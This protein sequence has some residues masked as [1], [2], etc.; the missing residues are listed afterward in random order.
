MTETQSQS[1]SRFVF[2]DWRVTT[3]AFLVLA[4]GN[5]HNVARRFLVVRSGVTA[6]LP[7][8]LTF[9]V[10]Q[11]R[12]DVVLQLYRTATNFDYVDVGTHRCSAFLPPAVDPEV[13]VPT[14]ES[15]GCGTLHTCDLGAR[16]S[17]LGDHT[18]ELQAGPLQTSRQ[19]C[20][21]DSIYLAGIIAVEGYWAE[22]PAYFVAS[23]TSVSS[24]NG[25][26]VGTATLQLITSTGTSSTQRIKVADL[27]G[28]GVVLPR[29]GPKLGVATSL[30]LQTMSS[31]TADAVICE[32]DDVTAFDM[33]HG[34]GN[35]QR[36]ACVLAIDGGGTRECTTV[37]EYHSFCFD[38][39]DCA[40]FTTIVRNVGTTASP[41]VV[42]EPL[43]LHDVDHS[44]RATDAAEAAALGGTATLFYAKRA[45]ANRTCRF[46][47]GD[48]SGRVAVYL[49][50][51]FFTG[52]FAQVHVV[53]TA[54][55]RLT[56]QECG[57]TKQFA[58]GVFGTESACD[59]YVL[60]D[61]VTVQAE[62]TLEVSFSETLWQASCDKGV[63]AFATFS[64][65]EATDALIIPQLTAADG[66]SV[67]SLI[68]P[69]TSAAR[70]NVNVFVIGADVAFL[71]VLQTAFEC[72]SEEC[73]RG[74][75]IAIRAV[76]EQYVLSGAPTADLAVMGSC[77]GTETFANGVS[78]LSG[79]CALNFDC[80][81]SPL[82]LNAGSSFTGIVAISVDAAALRATTRPFTTRSICSEFNAAVY[83]RAVDAVEGVPVFPLSV[84]IDEMRPL[85]AVAAGQLNSDAASFVGD[86]SA[87]SLP[88]TADRTVARVLTYGP[89]SDLR[90][91]TIVRWN[92]DDAAVRNGLAANAAFGC[93]GDSVTGTTT[94]CRVPVP[95][96]ANFVR[97]R[98]AQTDFA[99]NA[100]TVGFE[101]TDS[102]AVQTRVC[103]AADSFLGLWPALGVRQV[104]R[105]CQHLSARDHGNYRQRRR[106]RAQ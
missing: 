85:L 21:G 53:D 2:T 73:R 1:E 59:Q 57:R 55:N 16:S 98:V 83:A 64:P 97:V 39:I 41:L 71:R 22:G 32:A 63:S 24:G 78:G 94:T 44:Y 69:A 42:E 95:A 93:I 75:I 20:G 7:L 26:L 6:Q 62:A 90:D 103:G 56:R 58:A 51:S 102:T 13:P 27:D 81:D 4:D 79:Q 34:I 43:F 50:Q 67:R 35:G 76:S 25:V 104:P 106:L 92:A 48:A 3:N 31:A 96:R 100:V 60:C 84:T 18:L 86:G 29:Q 72:Q 11:Y 45:E 101:A 8:H 80:T 47:V 54:G 9:A 14:P 82:Q 46:R 70:Y 68:V 74:P 17:S 66:F 99:A 36:R 12:Q 40:G 91:M 19:P 88:I 105:L 33:H 15:F 37:D 65:A 10:A 5:G 61:E 49:A 28:G 30:P 23:S 52:A 38:D 87:G 77:G 89:R